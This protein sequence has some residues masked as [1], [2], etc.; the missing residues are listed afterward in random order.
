MRKEQHRLEKYTVCAGCTP[1]T[2]QK[3]KGYEIMKREQFQPNGEKGAV[4]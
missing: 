4:V 3:E 2:E 1:A